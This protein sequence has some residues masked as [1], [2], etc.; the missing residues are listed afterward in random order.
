M[1]ALTATAIV[2]AGYRD[3]Q[4]LGRGASLPADQLQEGLDRLNDM[5]NLWQTQGLKLFLEDEVTIPMQ[6][7]KQTYSMMPGGDLS[8]VR[9][10]QVKS[11]SFTDSG[12][13]T[14]P[15]T[16]IGRDDWSS[17]TNRTQSGQVTQFFAEKLYD[18]LNL[19]LW[20]AP[21]ATAATG[22]LMAVIRISTTDLVVGSDT[23]L[24]PPEWAIALRWGIADEV[25]YGMPPE[26]QQR[27]Q[28][29]AQAYR[30][31]L[32]DFD[33]EDVETTFQPDGRYTPGSR[34]R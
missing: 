4:K 11:A 33:V 10:L 5:K 15:L 20:Y 19:N 31:A 32:E 9:P 28:T 29:R 30:Q 22:T 25:S 12:G 17:L 27:C 13:S 21:D 34:F 7:M 26:L 8:I 24:F 1:T 2:T 16:P 14:R 23:L 18:R 6:V 3:A